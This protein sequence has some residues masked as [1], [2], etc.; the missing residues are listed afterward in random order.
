[1]P[2]IWTRQ[3]GKAVYTTFFVATTLLR[4]P[5]LC[6]IYLVLSMRPS[7]HWTFRQSLSRTLFVYFGKYA[8]TVELD[9]P[10][11]LEPGAE[12]DRFVII[13]PARRELYR[14]ILLCDET[15]KPGA[16]GAVWHMRP[17]TEPA[18]HR[19]GQRVFF[20]LH[21]GAY[22]LGDGR[23]I[24]MRFMSFLLLQ[25]CPDSAI[26]C[27]EY[28]LSSAAGGRFPA[29]MQD[30]VTA[31]SFLVHELQIPP[32]DIVLSGD[33]AGAHLAIA[34]LRYANA[35]PD[36]LPEPAAILLWS[37]WSDMII[38]VSIADERPATHVDHVAPE[39]ISWTY[40]EFL[41]RPETGVAR[42]DPYISPVTAAIPTEV[43]FWVQ[44]GS[45]EI[46]KPEITKFVEVQRSSQSRVETYESPHAPP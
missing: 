31:Y 16:V 3:P 24:G 11:A 12:K 37:P 46:L 7:R 33:S 10:P 15:I 6:A 5:W 8:A 26:F 41:P 2:S 28:R 20:H 22:V 21:G 32:Q 9:P 34:L 19:K 18:Q 13:Q 42:S 23:D 27:P 43:P 40:R 14:D 4:L 35:N 45:A 39:L 25:S 17:I 29:A 1:M 44:W 36:L 30:A 38:E